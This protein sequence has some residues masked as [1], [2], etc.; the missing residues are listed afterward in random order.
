MSQE[1]S[2]DN[3][4]IIKKDKEYNLLEMETNDEKEKSKHSLKI[5][6]IIRYIR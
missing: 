5:K 3:N 6:I 4:N 2:K 1:I